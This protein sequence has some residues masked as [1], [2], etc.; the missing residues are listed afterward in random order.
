VLWVGVHCDADVAAQREAA[1]QNRVKGM[2]AAQAGLV[3]SGVHY[4]IEVDTT[5][6][7]AIDCARTICQRVIR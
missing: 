3:H 6:L 5:N 4:D 2:A 7:P 1:R